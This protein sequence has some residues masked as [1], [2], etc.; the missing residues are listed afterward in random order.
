MNLSLQMKASSV[1]GPGVMI[2]GGV[3]EVMGVENWES[4]CPLEGF[5]VAQGQGYL[6][7]GGLQFRAPLVAH[8]IAGG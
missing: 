6:L 5:A 7:C 3:S 1:V 4:S 8:P 2:G